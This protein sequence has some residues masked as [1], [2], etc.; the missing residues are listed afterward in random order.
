MN[1]QEAAI[2]LNE[3]DW[4][5]ARIAKAMNC[6]QPTIFRIRTGMRD[7]RFKLATDLIALAKK[8]SRKK[9]KNHD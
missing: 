5:D 2:K 6:S 7:A 3:L 8:E 4:S 9:A 1:P